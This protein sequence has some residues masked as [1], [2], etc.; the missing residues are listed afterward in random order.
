MITVATWNV[1]SVKARLEI[2]C[3]WLRDNNPDVLLLQETKC[4]EEAFPRME[5]E[6]LGYNLAISGQKSY[7]GV[8]IV[9]KYPIED[10]LKKLPGDDSDEEARYIEGVITLGKSALRV[11]SIYVP[12]G[13]EVGSAKFLYKQRFLQRL[14]AHMSNIFALHEISV[15]GGDYNVAPEP[16]DVYDPK[17]MDGGIGFHPKER[18]LLRGL[19]NIGFIDAFRAMNR[20]TQAYSWWDYRAGSWSYDKGMRIDHLLVSPQAFDIAAK[21]YIDKSPRG[22]EKTS[23][24]TPVVIELD[25]A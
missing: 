11:A 24:H 9:S 16:I 13:M 21:C 6:D 20:E 12:N 8:A 3:G 25:I 23:D 22:L 4:V 10:V 15:F 19:H 5:F 7:N 1:N 14:H 2:V 17:G 18:E